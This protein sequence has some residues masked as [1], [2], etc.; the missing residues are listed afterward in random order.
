MAICRR[1]GKP[2][3][4]V[5]TEPQARGGALTRVGC[6]DCKAA[7]AAQPPKKPAV[8]FLRRRI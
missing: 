4:Q 8:G 3:D 5:W 6:V 7:A 1:H 2:K